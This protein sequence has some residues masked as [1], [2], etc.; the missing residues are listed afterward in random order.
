[1][2]SH[3]Q[4]FK[5]DDNGSKFY[6]NDKEMETLHKVGGPAMIW[7]D[8]TRAWYHNGELHRE[9]GPAVEYADGSKSWYRRGKLHRVGGPAVEWG[10]SVDDKEWFI[11][12]RRCSHE[13]YKQWYFR[14]LRDNNIHCNQD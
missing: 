4:Y 8:G 2:N 9:D 10:T 5:I 6:Y 12:G 11:H 3:K 7:A 14:Y 13:R 1:M